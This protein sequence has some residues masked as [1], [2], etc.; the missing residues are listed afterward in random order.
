MN[1]TIR[2]QQRWQNFD[3]AFDVL[4]RGLAIKSPSEFELRGIVQIFQFTF[5]LAWKTM[6]D[7][8]EG[9]GI[10]ATSPRDV[11]KQ[12]F[13]Y[14]YIDQGETWLT[15]LQQRNL[16]AHTYDE[17]MLHQ[18]IDLIRKQYYQHLSLLYTFL[19]GK[20]DKQT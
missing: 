13:H 1:K 5:E 8:L 18:A 16:L 20:L 10:E 11:L 4:T 15:M 17:K 14:S 12:A 2:W 19:S 9:E 6:K 3:R 7:Y